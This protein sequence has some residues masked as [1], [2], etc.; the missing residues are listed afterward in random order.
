MAQSSRP[1]ATLTISF[2]LVAIPVKLYSATVTTE[3]ISFHLL[4]KSDGSRLKEQY[5]AVAD[6]KL[7]ERSETVKGYEFAKGKH[8]MFTPEE[9]KILDD[10]TSS[11]LEIA[12]FVP[13][14]SVDPVYF[15]ATYYLLPD[16]GGAKPYSLLSTAL[17]QESRCA[18]GKWISRGREH[19]IIIRPIEDG[20]ALHQLHFKAEVRPFA[21]FGLTATKVAEAEIKLARQLIDH[22]AARR[23]DPNEFVD[24]HRSRVQAEIDRKIRGKQ[25]SMTEPQGQ[26]RGDNVINLMDALRASLQG[27]ESPTKTGK[28][29]KK[30]PSKRASKTA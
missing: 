14:E 25:I 10:A 4:R 23:F 9:L 8:V 18:V 30:P 26:K 1:I 21:D 19:V 11:T 29:S 2:G 27:R 7:V 12:Q 13:I 16:K 5:V 17:R 20:L 6:G 24:E 3:R 28:I 22:L 15:M